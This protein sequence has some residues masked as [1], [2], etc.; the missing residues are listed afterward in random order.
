[1]AINLLPTDIAPK[2]PIN[3]TA[4]VL[5]RV[6]IF[7]VVILILFLAGI[8]GYI[9]FLQRQIVASENNQVQLEDSIKSLQQIEQSLVLL[10]DR[11]KRANTILADETV[12]PAL[13]SFAELTVTIPPSVRLTEAEITTEGTELGFLAPSSS[14][15]AQ[16]MANL[17]SIDEY[18]KITLKSF[19]FSPTSGY[20]VS[21]ELE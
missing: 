12:T 4:N 13:D 7:G 19:G 18:E 9:F 3:K 2:S 21:L 10:K 16:L 17:Y 20:L 1:M 6:A 5:K 14:L 11:I 15:L 8:G